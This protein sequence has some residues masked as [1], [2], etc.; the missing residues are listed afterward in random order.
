MSSYTLD[1]LERVAKRSKLTLEDAIEIGHKIT[2][3][4][5]ERIRRSVSADTKE[6]RDSE[7]RH[8]DC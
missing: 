1:L 5:S 2:K 4:A 6:V 7:T 8:Q 3:R